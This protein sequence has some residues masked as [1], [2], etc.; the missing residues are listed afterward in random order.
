MNDLNLTWMTWIWLE[1]DLNDLNMTWMTWIWLEWLEYDLNDLND[2][3]DNQ[4]FYNLEISD[5]FIENYALSKKKFYF[6]FYENNFKW[7]ASHSNGLRIYGAETRNKFPTKY[8]LFFS[9]ES[10]QFVSFIVSPD[11]TSLLT[12]GFIKLHF[13]RGFYWTSFLPRVLLNFIFTEGFI[14]LHFYKG[15]YWTSFFTE[16]APDP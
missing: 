6:T 14:E 9:E 10:W 16:V 8:V 7:Q 1:Y 13:Y 15:L 3:N 4:K 5:N 11:G 2:L 12:E